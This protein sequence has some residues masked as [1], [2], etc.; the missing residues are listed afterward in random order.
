MKAYHLK[1][2]I[3]SWNKQRSDETPI[4]NNLTTAQ[5]TVIFSRTFHQ[6]INMPSTIVARKFYNASLNNNWIDAE[7]YLR[8]YN[9]TAKYY[10][11]RVN[12][13]ADLLKQENLFK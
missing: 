5:Q 3:D 13:E 7:R 6:G 12:K 9:V 10:V 4:Y 1:A 2:A 11:D 8:N